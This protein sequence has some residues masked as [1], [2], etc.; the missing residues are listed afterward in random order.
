MAAKVALEKT[1]QKNI[2]AACERRGCY[3]AKCNAGRYGQNGIPDLFVCYRSR[4][5]AMEVK[6][7]DWVESDVTTLQRHELTK[8]GKADG[9]A[10]VV[11]SVEAAMV[12]LDALD[13]AIEAGTLP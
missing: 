8:I 7:A 2:K 11:G 13:A 4:F 12:V 10:V 3:V 1:V 6:R 9:L 5:V